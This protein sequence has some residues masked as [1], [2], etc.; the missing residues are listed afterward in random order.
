MF[1]VIETRAEEEKGEEAEIARL[2]IERSTICLRLLLPA[3]YYRSFE[4]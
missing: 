4:G 2:S 3:S 1:R